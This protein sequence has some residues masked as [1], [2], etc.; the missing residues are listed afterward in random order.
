MPNLKIIHLE[1][2]ELDKG[3][4]QGLCP[5]EGSRGIA[6]PKLQTI[7]FR[8][9]HERDDPDGLG[10]PDFDF[11]LELAAAV[12]S[13]P[14]EKMVLGLIEFRKKVIST[15]EDAA[16]LEKRRNFIQWLQLKVPFFQFIDDEHLGDD[17]ERWNL[18]EL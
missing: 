1:Y 16:E 2:L 12:K 18:W 17:P 11:E 9:C 13:H 4:L 14:L 6:F 3:L 8:H 7:E 15:P 10:D 5:P